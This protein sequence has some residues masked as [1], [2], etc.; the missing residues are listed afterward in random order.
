MITLSVVLCF[1]YCKVWNS[2]D[3]GSVII[4]IAASKLSTRNDFSNLLNLAL[5]L[6]LSIDSGV[7]NGFLIPV[8][9][10]SSVLPILEILDTPLTG[11]IVIAGLLNSLLSFC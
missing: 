11:I 4:I 2:D 8:T 9:S 5:L 10:L 7:N 3:V 1:A 6:S